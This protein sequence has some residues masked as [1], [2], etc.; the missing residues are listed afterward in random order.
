VDSDARVCPFCGS[1]PGPGVFCAACGRN[2]GAVE[3][4]PTRA[5]WDTTADPAPSSLSAPPAPDGFDTVPRF[6][7]EMHAAGDPGVAKL[8]RAQP[9]FLGRTQHARGW[10]VRPV[11]EEREPGLFLTVDGALH[12][13]ES[14]TLGISNRG[15]TFIDVVGA[16][17]EAPVADELATILRANGLPW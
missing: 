2:L 8:P 7:A 13:L 5:Q 1:L 3:Q 14:T 6:L 17:T 12:R 9:G 15:Q 11:G 10:I 16:E 4:L